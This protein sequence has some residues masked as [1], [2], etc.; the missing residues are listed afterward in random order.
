MTVGERFPDIVSQLK[1]A[2]RIIK[3]CEKEIKN[4]KITIRR[5]LELWYQYKNMTSEEHFFMICLFIVRHLVRMIV[6]VR[7]YH[8]QK[9][10]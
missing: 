8:V 5:T 2:R 4:N 10:Q 1:E 3:K 6:C 9:K 7:F